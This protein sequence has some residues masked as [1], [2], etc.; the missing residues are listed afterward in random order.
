[1]IELK[2]F[3]DAEHVAWSPKLL[4][5]CIQIIVHE[6]AGKMVP[7]V[8]VP[9]KTA[10]DYMVRMVPSSLIALTRLQAWCLD[11]GAG[12]IIVP[13]LEKA[14]ELKEVVAACRFP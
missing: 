4:V 10:F 6:S 2:L 9:S 1:M 12:G 13:H 3:Q 7:V 5:E 14:E 8:R 11:A